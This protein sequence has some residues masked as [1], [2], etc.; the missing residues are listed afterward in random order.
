MEKTEK[1]KNSVYFIFHGGCPDG[2]YAALIW[3]LFRQACAAQKLDFYQAIED[4]F[5]KPYPD[6]LTFNP[7]DAAASDKHRPFE[8]QVD[9]ASQQPQ[10]YD[11]VFY[12]PVIH[13]TTGRD[14]YRVQK[15]E[16]RKDIAIIADIGNLEVLRKL[17]SSF[18]QVYFADHHLSSLTEG[19]DSPDFV[20]Q[21]ANVKFFYD[22]KNSACKLLYNILYPTG[23]LQATYSQKFGANL[24]FLVDSVSLGDVNSAVN[25]P[26]NHRRIKNGLCSLS[27]I[28][29]F[30][31][32]QSVLHLR[33]IAD[34]SHETLE[35]IGTEVL[36][37]MEK[38]IFDEI[39]NAKPGCFSY[40]S[41]SS[42]NQV[43]KISFLMLHTKSKFRSEIGNYLSEEA[44]KRGLDPIGMVYVNSNTASSYKASWRALD[45]KADPRINMMEVCGLFGGGGHRLA[46]GCE[47]SDQDIRRMLGNK[48][49]AKPVPTPEEVDLLYE[50]LAAIDE[51]PQAAA[52][53]QASLPGLPEAQ[54]PT[55]EQPVPA[56]PPADN[57]APE[58]D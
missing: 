31:K 27:D 41:K 58:K 49:L 52:G 6:Q 7:A 51:E 43:V 37:R 24:T 12:F 25:L 30:T 22:H 56:Q 42:G 29:N 2:F 13:T 9:K 33:K 11:D 36:V 40:E 15:C 57:P 1:H 20:K 45:D 55:Q 38:E 23:I 10:N 16:E 54:D 5:G 35:Q 39:K 21:H 4:A 32:N 50:D 47:L 17:H 44:R 46:S 53:L 8:G 19:L 18:G 14:I 3:D 28:Y 48:N 34:F 26:L